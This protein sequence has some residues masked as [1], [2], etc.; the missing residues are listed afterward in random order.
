MDEVPEVLKWGW[1]GVYNMSTAYWIHRVILNVAQIK[2]DYMI[3]DIRHLQSS[4]E[5]KSIQLLDEIVQTNDADFSD[6]VLKNAQ[7]AL[8]SSKELIHYLLFT[9]ADG[10]VNYWKEDTF[11]SQAVGYPAWWLEAVGYP[12]G[13]PPVDT[14]SPVQKLHFRNYIASQDNTK[15]NPKENL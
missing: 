13:P 7:E 15:F 2:F 10:Y 9:Y 8:I 14:E 4:L 12:N 6:K 3:E 11:H 1:Q 5:S